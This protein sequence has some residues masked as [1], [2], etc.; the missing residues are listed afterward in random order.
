VKLFRIVTPCRNAESLIR[1]TIESVLGQTAVRSG[2]ARLDYRIIDG[3]SS[4]GTVDIASAYRS[5]SVTLISEPDEGMYDALAKGLEGVED[6]ICAYLNAGDLYSPRAFDCVLDVLSGRKASWLTG[7]EVAYNE[8]SQII[9][10]T[11]PFRYRRRLFDCGAYGTI[12]PFVQQESTFWDARLNRLIDFARLRRFR[13]AGDYYLWH[14]FSALEPLR[15]VESH[16][17]G[18]RVHHGQLSAGNL[19]AY[20]AEMAAI[21]REMTLADRC[22]AWVD[23]MLWDAPTRVK[24]AL[25]REGLLR[26]DSA[27]GA[28]V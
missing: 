13:Y 17:G 15:I 18:F 25:N 6:G 27:R 26:Y 2:R 14:T 4:D 22:I 1:E 5:S 16:L 8:R 11:L 7:L 10:V 3:A 28:W 21:C 9:R 23:R 12:L 24:K 20:R 19:G